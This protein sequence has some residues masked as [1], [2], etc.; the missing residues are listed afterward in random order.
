MTASLSRETQGLETLAAVSYLWRTQQRS[1][2]EAMLDALLANDRY[3]KSPLL[4][5]LAGRMA[6]AQGRPARAAECLDRALALQFE[7]RPKEVDLGVFRTDYGELLGLFCKAAEETPGSDAALPDRLI[8]RI[9][10]SADRWRSVDP[11][12][13]EVCRLAGAA[14]AR[15]GAIDLAWDYVTSPLAT[16]EQTSLNWSALGATYHRQGQ[17][18]LADRAY[19]LACADDPANAELLWN[20]ARVLIEANR[21]NEARGLLETLAAGSWKPEYG[22]IQTLAKK[23]LASERQRT[24]DSPA[25]A[26]PATQGDGRRRFFLVG[27]SLTGSGESDQAGGVRFGNKGSWG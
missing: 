6:E 20:R 1:R 16:D 23:A 3:E 21:R 10:S 5:R 19:E 25:R 15:C 14:L 4:W 8:S 2:A 17:Y 7:H 22:W 27:E 12:S 24:T 18:E 9:V 26:S 13:G 11:Q